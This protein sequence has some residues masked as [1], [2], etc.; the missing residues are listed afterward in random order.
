M[1]HTLVNYILFKFLYF[2]LHLLLILTERILKFNNILLDLFNQFI[3]CYDY[4]LV[5]RGYF[6]LIQIIKLTFPYLLL[7]L[8]LL[9]ILIIRLNVCYHILQFTVA[10]FSQT[11]DLFFIKFVD[12]FFNL[13]FIFFTLFL[14]IQFLL[15][16]FV[17]F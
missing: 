5:L 9:F 3:S 6:I 12:N 16:L 4:I 15:P 8:F 1:N 11:L 13:T 2:I 7:L 17:H 10:L 14:I